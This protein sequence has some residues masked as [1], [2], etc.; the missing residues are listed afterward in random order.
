M[1]RVLLAL[2]G[3]KGF[4]SDV[5]RIFRRQAIAAGEPKI[6]L[7]VRA[8]VDD[9]DQ[10]FA[11]PGFA[12]RWNLAAARVAPAVLGVEHPVADTGRHRTIVS[13][14]HP[15]FD[16]TDLDILQRLQVRFPRIEAG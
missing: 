14:S 1:P 9:R 10:V 7:P 13:F 4:L 8:A 2:T 6:A 12:P 5:S 15:F 3:Y 11:G 16:G